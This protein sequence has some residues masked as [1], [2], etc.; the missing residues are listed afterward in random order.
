[1]VAAFRTQGAKAMKHP[2]PVLVALT[3][4]AGLVPYGANAA[5]NIAVFTKNTTNPFSKAIRLG[6]DA[7]AKKLGVVVSHYTPTTADNAGEQTKLVNDAIQAK[8]DAIVFD[9]VDNAAMAP[10]AEKINAANIPVVDI[11]DRSSGGKFV[12]YV[13][14]DDYQLGL[15][16][17]RAL[18][19]AMGGKGNVVILEG[20]PNLTSTVERN[21]G[22]NAAIKENPAVMLLASKSGQYQRRPSQTLMEGWIRQ[23]PQIDGVMAA[24]DSM[25]AAAADT[26]Q[27]RKRN[28]LVVGINGSPEAIELIKGGKM[29]A[30]GE[31]NGFVIGCLG[32]EIAARNLRK[33]EVP[34]ELMVKPIIYDK[35]NYQKYQAR[36]DEKE[37][38]TVEDELKN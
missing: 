20:I 14:P 7:A 2:I 37:C 29:L 8:P 16:T 3:M 24:N 21:K 27:A 36:I 31:Y 13:L 1:M 38:P 17:G 25:A 6:A 26:L 34:A 19:K 33:Q 30:S 28:A 12:S 15:S 4:T 10:A 23:F 5:E 22:F 35:D 18:I 32:V 9:P 11:T